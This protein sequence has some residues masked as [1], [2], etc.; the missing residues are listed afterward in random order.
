MNRAGYALLV[1]VAVLGALSVAAG[2]AALAAQTSSAGA[3]A[4]LDQAR[5]RAAVE[6]AA[7]RTAV[8]FSLEDEALRWIP[9]G[10]AYTFEIDDIAVIVRPVAASGLFDLN[11]G[12]VEVLARL[13]EN[14]GAERRDAMS[15]SGAVADWRDA[16]EDRSQ[17]GAEAPAYRASGLPPPANRNFLA[18]EEF[19]RVLGV[20]AEIYRNTA[21]YLTVDGGEAVAALYALPALLEALDRPA[22]DVRQILAARRAGS[23]LPEIEDAGVFDPAS[24]GRYALFI[25]AQTAS[26]AALA[27]QLSIILPG[28]DGPMDVIRR[29]PMAVGE[30]E[31]LLEPDSD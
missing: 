2:M 20:D 16:D 22:G 25:E 27:R 14:V 5:L 29:A 13:L 21:P 23:E 7:A 11:S 19:R 1:V 4:D 31:Q 24:G 9:D 28:Q 8:G 17:N 10:R 26:G 12:N 18:I 30:A 6:A 3:R 15:I